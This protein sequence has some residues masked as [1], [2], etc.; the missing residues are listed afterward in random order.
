MT[1]EYLHLSLIHVSSAD[2]LFHQ[3]ELKLS[4]PLRYCTL[5]TQKDYPHFLLHSGSLLSVA[6]LRALRGARDGGRLRRGSRSSMMLRQQP[7]RIVRGFGVGAGV[8]WCQ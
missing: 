7:K 2:E 5:Q 1:L 8:G 4:H 6:L 3:A